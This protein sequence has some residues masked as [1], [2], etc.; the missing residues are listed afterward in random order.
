M[1]RDWRD[2][3]EL[4]LAEFSRILIGNIKVKTQ[5]VEES[6]SNII[7][8][9][10]LVLSSLSSGKIKNLPDCV[11]LLEELI[12][13]FDIDEAFITDQVPMIVGSKNEKNNRIS[14]VGFIFDDQLKK[15]SRNTFIIDKEKNQASFLVEEETTFFKVELKLTKADFRSN[16]YFRLKSV[17]GNIEKIIILDRNFL[18]SKK[19]ILLGV[20][21]S[22]SYRNIKSQRIVFIKEKVET[23]P[24]LL[25]CIEKYLT[26]KS[27]QL[28]ISQLKIKNLESFQA[29]TYKQIENRK[30]VFLDL[31]EDL[32][33]V[34][35]QFL[36][37]FPEF[38]KY[39]AGVK[40]EFNTHRVNGR[41]KV[42][43]DTLGNLNKNQLDKSLFEF[44][45]VD[46]EE[47]TRFDQN[48]ENKVDQVARRF[49]IREMQ[50][51]VSMFKKSLSFAKEKNKSLEDEVVYLRE[52]NN[53]LIDVRERALIGEDKISNITNS[54]LEKYSSDRMQNAVISMSKPL[55]VIMTNVRNLIK[56]G[57]VEEALEVLSKTS[58]VSI[59]KDDLLLLQNNLSVINRLELLGIYDIKYLSR[60]KRRITHAVIRMLG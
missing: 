10:S 42:T 29:F 41:L 58:D 59:D 3:E 1:R 36:S 21:N 50:H 45:N 9:D 31:P 2:M 11:E 40:I 57:K 14:F 60:E 54:I 37:Y 38:V 4:E 16:R 30:E 5:L 7:G 18:I 24:E 56:N 48:H 17:D 53:K 35:Q 39:M 26:I 15:L 25:F 28:G 33:L 51:Q 32:L 34:F 52:L 47:L 23:T 49:F 13:E 44:I 12:I 19:D 22:I 46:N 27:I 55:I 8:V 43:I 6:I 20:I